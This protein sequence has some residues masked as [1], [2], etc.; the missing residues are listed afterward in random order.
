MHGRLSVTTSEWRA[1]LEDVIDREFVA[2]CE[3]EGDEGVT[4]DEVLE[5][6]STIED[7]MARVILD[8]E[9]AERF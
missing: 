3:S 8:E 5:A 9:R 2:Y 4:P 6:T 7:S 1:A